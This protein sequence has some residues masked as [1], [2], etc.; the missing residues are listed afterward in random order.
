MTNRNQFLFIAKL[1]DRS[2]QAANKLVSLGFK[3][4]YN[5]DGGIMKWNGKKTANAIAI[6][7]GMT[8]SDFEKLT[9][10]TKK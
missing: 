1:A 8:V 4:V 2:S 3:E 6:P 5:L 7:T 10:Q 9:I